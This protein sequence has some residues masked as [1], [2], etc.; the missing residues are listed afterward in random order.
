[1]NENGKINDEEL[2][3]AAGGMIFNAANTPEDDFDPRFPWEVIDNNN[4]KV[5]GK[6]ATYDQACQYAKSFGDDSYNTMQVYWD[7]VS[8][9]RANPNVFPNPQ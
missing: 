1:M 4:G 5:L 8:R 6:F 7:T 2:E 9:L 3:Q